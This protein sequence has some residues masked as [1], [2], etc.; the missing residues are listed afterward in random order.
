MISEILTSIVLRE[1]ANQMAS[2]TA[3]E[4]A[5][6]AVH[7]LLRSTLFVLIFQLS[8]LELYTHAR[9]ASED[10]SCLTEGS[11]NELDRWLE[12]FKNAKIEKDKK[13]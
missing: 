9:P 5:R 8:P 12:E 1:V 4:T 11:L 13:Q 7:L 3:L 2:E 6:A 10:D